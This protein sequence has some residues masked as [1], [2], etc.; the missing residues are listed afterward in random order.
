VN[1]ALAVL[2]SYLNLN[3]LSPLSAPYFAFLAASVASLL[4]L[5]LT[6]KQSP[7]VTAF[8]VSSLGVQELIVSVSFDLAAQIGA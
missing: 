2:P 4:A 8:S 5:S 1:T 7:V 6:T 3:Y